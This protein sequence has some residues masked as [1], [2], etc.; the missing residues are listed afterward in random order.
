MPIFAAHVS[1]L[2]A[3]TEGFKVEG[4][5]RFEDLL[6]IRYKVKD[7][8]MESGHTH[9]VTLFIRDYGNKEENPRHISFL[10]VGNL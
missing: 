9:A 7:F 5:F 4:L 6:K 1:I 3:H 2:A 8:W 10:N